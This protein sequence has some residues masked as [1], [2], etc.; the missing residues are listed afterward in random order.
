MAVYKET[1]IRD[2]LVNIKTNLDIQL[3]NIRKLSNAKMS[4]T[5][6]VK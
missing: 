3:F 1:H 6:E 5:Q 4:K 2:N